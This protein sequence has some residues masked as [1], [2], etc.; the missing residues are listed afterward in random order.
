MTDD[1]QRMVWTIGLR[2][3][4]SGGLEGIMSEAEKL[5]QRIGGAFDGFDDWRD[6][7]DAVL[8]GVGKKLADLGVDGE[9]AS[10]ALLKVEEVFAE[11]ATEGA[12]AR[13]VLS[14]MAK[15]L[16]DAG[17]GGGALSECMANLTEAMRSAWKPVEDT[18]RA[19]D[20]LLKALDGIGVPLPMFTKQLD[21]LEKQ[22]DEFNRSGEDANRLLKDSEALFESMVGRGKEL[23]GLM[24]VLHGLTDARRA[25]ADET[26]KAARE[27]EAAARA[28][29]RAAKAALT[30]ESALDRARKTVE[31][32]AAKTRVLKEVT[33]RLEEAY[34]RLRKAAP[35]SERA[36]E[37]AEEIKVLTQ[38]AR[39]LGGTA[40]R[41]SDSARRGLDAA[42]RAVA[43]F[44]R[45]ARTA[46][47]TLG[48]FMSLLGGTGGKIAA[49]L[50]AFKIGWDVG[51]WIN[52]NLLGFRDAGEELAKANRKAARE[53]ARAYGEWSDALDDLNEGFEEVARSEAGERANIDATAAAFGRLRQA[54][55]GVVRANEELEDSQ[56][57]LDRFEDV[58]G[59]ERDGNAVAAGQVSRYYDVLAAE[60]QSE[61]RLAAFDRDHEATARRRDDGMARIRSLTSEDIEN[62]SRLLE[63]QRQ[64]DANERRRGGG[65]YD[66]AARDRLEREIERAEARRDQ[67]A[68][69]LQGARADVDAA[70]AALEGDGTRRAA[71]ERRLRLEVD[72]RKKAYDDYL[73]EVERREQE[74]HRR[75]VEQDAA[76]DGEALRERLARELDEKRRLYQEEAEAWREARSNAEA[77]LSAAKSQ[78]ETAWGWYRDRGA[79]RARIR[80]EETDAEARRRYERDYASLVHGR[81]AS[82]FSEARELQRLGHLDE[83]EERMG[84]WRRRKT[85]SLGD[86]ATMRV[87]LAREEERNARA[88]VAN[89]DRTLQRIDGN[90]AKV[91]TMEG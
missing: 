18:N 75:Q 5:R 27:Q 36:R 84:E 65:D 20:G 64:R 68:R 38:A 78:A 77:R 25:Q 2:D 88:A 70:N 56:L 90:L 1:E 48:R 11:F 73:G 85:L 33:D 72:V 66:I 91:L 76:M 62:D 14:E 23:D 42:G 51:T 44:E 86:E 35:S 59:L 61:R 19:F 39:D 46:S 17:V 21:G 83:L 43:E 32:S 52:K 41:S 28:A 31:D 54:M 50:G 6:K 3:E 89:I 34:G 12:P 4:I 82:K 8:D 55:G 58:A 10:G 15:A 16:H 45:R 40:V 79:L 22:I 26:R 63:L 13:G 67:L 29:E 30:V 71:L 81:A 57:E 47:G 24:A 37:L 7:L 74:S 9:R 49:A 60:R 69:E 53:A 87:A 80:E